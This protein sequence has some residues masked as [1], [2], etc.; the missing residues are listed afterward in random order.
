MKKGLKK[1]MPAVVFLAAAAMIVGI[2]YWI[3][4]RPKQ[5]AAKRINYEREVIGDFLRRLP[6]RPEG[7]PG[8]RAAG[9]TC[10]EPSG[11]GMQGYQY[12]DV[13]DYS[14]RGNIDSILVVDKINMEKAII[15]G[16]T[17]ED[18]DF[19]LDR[20]YFVTADQTMGLDGNYIIYGHC[21]MT[22][23]HS[24][25]RLDEL[26]VGDCFYL[27]QNG[28]KYDYEVEAKDK[29]L[30]AQSNDYFLEMEKRVTF[31]SCEKRIQPGFSE[32]RV[33]IVRSRQMGKEVYQTN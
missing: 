31:V 7:A 5:E 13:D 3:Y 24:F 9:D 15:R 19:N 20:Y 2:G 10:R 26:E 6:D 11:G 8:T 28:M 32:N 33:I 4:S 29:V 27:I 22:Y 16:N 25:N 17:P 14:F 12:S 30:R 18:N 1:A 23:G 21:S